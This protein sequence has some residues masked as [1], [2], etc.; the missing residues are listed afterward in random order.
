MTFEQPLKP[1]LS[2][3]E[4]R[5]RKADQ[6]QA[7]RLKMAIGRKLDEQGATTPAAIGAALDLPVT[8]AAALLNRKRLR[9]GDL[10]QLEAA[11]VRLGL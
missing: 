10:A 1:Q 3:A 9:D 4:R 11:A 7:I 8:E 5:A 2:A 6:L